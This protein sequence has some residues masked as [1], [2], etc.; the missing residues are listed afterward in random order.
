MTDERITPDPG[1][2]TD[3]RVAAAYRD[4]A[5]ERAPEPLN[6]A[7]LRIAEK[8]ARPPYKRSILWTR[9]AAWIAVVAI[10]LA[11]TLQVTQ[12]P[13]PTD[14]PAATEL[15]PLDSANDTPDRRESEQYRK[16]QVEKDLPAGRSDSQSPSE[17][18][19]EP[20]S[21]ALES[22]E[23]P[24]SRVEAVLEEPAPALAED[25]E[26]QDADMLRRAED[27][28]R[29]QSGDIKTREYQEHDPNERDNGAAR[30]S[31]FAAATAPASLDDSGCG[32]ADRQNPEDWLDCIL[33][34]E[35]ADLME[36][37]ARQRELLAETFP[38]FEIPARSE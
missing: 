7:V 13:T 12:V 4:L 16:R 29:L 20:E 22:T 23:V 18:R 27:M 3:E 35:S 33:A 19:L 10:C 1:A 15:L 9:P 26:M 6:T 32:T 28:V 5:T 30:A 34:L 14:M 21:R 24:E 25:F 37:A 36:E 8:A 38:D 2:A 11:I 31:G 17:D